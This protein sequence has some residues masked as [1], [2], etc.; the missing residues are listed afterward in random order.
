MA[1][2]ME[3]DPALNRADLSGVTAPLG[4]VTVNWNG[5]Q[6]TLECLEAIFRM[7][8]FLGP[9]VVVDNGSHDGSIEMLTA[10]AIGEVC[11]VPQSRQPQI[12]RLVIPPVTKPITARILDPL[13]LLTQRDS[14]DSTCRLFIVRA[15]QNLGFAAANNLGIKLLLESSNIELI[16]FINNDALPREDAFME[17]TCAASWAAGPLICGSVLLEYKEP[18]TI[19]AL[20]GRYSLYS[21]V[22]THIMAGMHANS[23]MTLEQRVAVDYPVGAAMLVNRSFITKYGL[24]CEEY[25]LYFEEID[26]ALRMSRPRKAYAVPRSIVFHKGG[27]ATAAGRKGSTRSLLAD[28][29]MLR[30][31]LLLA[32]RVSL[33]AFIS[34]AML[35]PGMVVR[36]MFRKRKGLVINAVN[37]V[38]DG[39][40]GHS[41]MRPK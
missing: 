1:T 20:G 10:W 4:I 24:M 41:G 27:A 34:C 8:G 30:N 19:Q 23:L 21:G 9:V 40:L 28:Y 18:T 31:R 33:G 29:Y 17:I 15:G 3:V 16:W 25:F 7:Q 26:W 32:R 38:K 37:A 22:S 36:R 14:L 13:S 39:L 5:W 2:C 11:V 6:D 35:A 12:E